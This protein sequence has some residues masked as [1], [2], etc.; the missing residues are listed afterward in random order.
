[1]H[2]AESNNAEGNTLI[3]AQKIL[4]ET[5][6]D[7]IRNSSAQEKLARFVVTSPVKIMRGTSAQLDFELI[8][9]DDL[10]GPLPR[11]MKRLHEIKAPVIVRA[12]PMY[13]P[14]ILAAVA[15]IRIHVPKY[16]SETDRIEFQQ[17]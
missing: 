3:V 9:V 5:W 8:L 7:E 15:G 13:I 11:L 2:W 16:W 10:G 12:N 1:M 17:L 6:R 14:K 4:H